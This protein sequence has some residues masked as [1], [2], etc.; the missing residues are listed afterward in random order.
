MH[1]RVLKFHI[2][3]PHK[4][5]ADSS[6]FAELWPFEKILMN[7]CQQNILKLL[8]LEPLNLVNRLVSMSRWPD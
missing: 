8:K 4:K 6:P 3:I 5:I 1:A 2:W 7:S